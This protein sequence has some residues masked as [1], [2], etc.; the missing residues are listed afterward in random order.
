MLLKADVAVAIA[1]RSGFFRPA[2][3]EYGVAVHMGVAGAFF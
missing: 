2:A 1:A 3:P